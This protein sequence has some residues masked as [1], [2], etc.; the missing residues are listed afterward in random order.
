MQTVAEWIVIGCF[1]SCGLSLFYGLAELTLDRRFYRL[2]CIPFPISR[3][4]AFRE[5]PARHSCVALGSRLLCHV[6]PQRAVFFVYDKH[7]PGSPGLFQGT[8]KD[9]NG[10][11]RVT[12]SVPAGV[13]LFLTSV[14]IAF[15][16]QFVVEI[17][18]L[19]LH[20]LIALVGAWVIISSMLFVL[21]M[22]AY[23]SSVGCVEEVARYL[24]L[25]PVSSDM[26]AA[27]GSPTEKRPSPA[28]ARDHER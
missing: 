17:R 28:A 14:L 13:P 18:D 6:G 8:A 5:L 10:K 12:I 24:R 16:S 27:P 7:H 4:Y 22:E 26:E 19:T 23:L 15:T 9:G 20:S 1:V 11:V 3:T 21:S 2:Y 25:E